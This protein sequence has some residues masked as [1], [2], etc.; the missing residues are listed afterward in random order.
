MRRETLKKATIIV[1][2]IEESSKIANCDI[3]KEILKEFSPWVYMI[4][5]GKKI[6]KVTVK[7]RNVPTRKAS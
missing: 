1:S 4:P 2:L 7:G 5:W 6:E 3:E